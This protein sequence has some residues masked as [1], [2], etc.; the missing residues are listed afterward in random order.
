MI[1]Q[2]T[3]IFYTIHVGVGYYPFIITCHFTSRSFLLDD[4][5]GIEVLMYSTVFEKQKY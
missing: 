4:S 2:R 1:D 3:L 5:S